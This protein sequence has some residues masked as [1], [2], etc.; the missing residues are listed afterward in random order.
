MVVNAVGILRESGNATFQALHVD[1]PVAL[2]HACVQADVKKVV[3]ISALGADTE[4]ASRYHLSKKHADDTL[5]ELPI[6]WVIMQPSLVFG[7][8]AYLRSGTSPPLLARY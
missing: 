7:L 5:A 1:A 6:R 8:G 3:Q 2:F 4:A